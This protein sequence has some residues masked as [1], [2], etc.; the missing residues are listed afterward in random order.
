MKLEIENLAKKA[1]ASSLEL[2]TLLPKEKNN[3]LK[4]IADEISKEVSYILEENLKDVKQ[5]RS[6]GVSESLIDRMFSGRISPLV[7][8]FAKKNSLQKQDV[9]ELK[10]LIEQ[11]EQ[12][13]D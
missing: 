7:A 9:E 3:L 6:E 8:G 10:A 12:D 5:Q 2:L 4:A 11:W 13:N 1:K